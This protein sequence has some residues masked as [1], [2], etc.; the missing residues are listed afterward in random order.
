MAAIH[1]EDVTGVRSRISWA[2]VLAGAVV[3]LATYLLLGALGV[4]LGLTF[5]Q[6]VGDQELGIAAAAYA[7]ISLLLAL[8]AG[9]CV[10]SRCTAGENTTEAI[11]YGVVLWGVVFAAMLWMT[12]GGIRMGFNAVMGIA[13][14]PAAGV[15]ATRMSDADLKASGLTD[16][17]IKS[18]QAQFD[19]MRAR[20]DNLPA[21]VRDAAR[22]PRTTAAAWWTF[23]GLLLSM[24]AAIGGALLGAG[25]NLLLTTLRVRTT[26]VGTTTRV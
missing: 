14:S 13:T 20:A 11:L 26:G 5:N 24:G 7:V 8:F 18:V 3:T 10:V 2:A 15:V 23:A 19:R 22:D 17:Q 16:E 21:E 12:A 25:P 6:N 4:A 9:G 1:T